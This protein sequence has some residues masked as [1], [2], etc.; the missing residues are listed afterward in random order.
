M[1]EYDLIRRRQQDAIDRADGRRGRSAGNAA[2]V[3]QIFNGGAMPTTVP[4]FYVGHTVKLSGSETEGG[5]GTLSAGS[6][7]VPVMIIDSVPA[8]GDNVIA[9]RVGGRWVAERG[10]AATC[11]GQ[12]CVRVDGCGKFLLGATVSIAPHGGGGVVASGTTDSAGRYCVTL[13]SSGSYDATIAFPDYVTQT[14][15]ASYTCSATVNVSVS[16]TEP[17]GFVCCSTATGPSS[18]PFPFPTTLRYSNPCNGTIVSVTNTSG[19]ECTWQNASFQFK[20]NGDGT[21][22]FLPLLSGCASQA[23]APATL[24]VSVTFNSPGTG[25]DPPHSGCVS[26]SPQWGGPFPGAPTPYPILLFT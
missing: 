19:N 22:T 17:T 3:L 8:V 25:C 15:T 10:V 1:G 16:L 23:T 26:G 14:V 21:W 20:Y 18:V 13:P 11:T 2:K 12:F 4:N 7:R 5:A 6:D 24:P 9:R